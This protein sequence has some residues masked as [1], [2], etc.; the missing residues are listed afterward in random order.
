MTNR[1]EVTKQY[2]NGCVQLDVTN[3]YGTRCYYLPAKSVKNFGDDLIKHNKKSNL[4]SNIA[5]GTS[6]IVG[7]LGTSLF[8]KKMKKINDLT[9]KFIVAAILAGISGYFTNEYNNREH[10]KLTQ[11]YNAREIT[12][13]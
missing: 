7:I 13:A 1:I 10:D 4:Y 3:S 6:A 12:N 11:K 2:N 9:A 8:T 5:L